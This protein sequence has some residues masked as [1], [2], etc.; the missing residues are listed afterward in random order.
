M[1][2]E[3]SELR[4]G[5]CFLI[6]L[7]VVLS[8][9]TIAEV[10][11]ADPIIVGKWERTDGADKYTIYANGVTETILPD[12]IHHGTW[13]YDG[14]SGY[15][16]IF[17][18]DF[19]PSGK[20]SFVDYVTVTSDGQKYSGI[21]NYGDDFHCV[22]VGDT[23]AAKSGGFPIVYVAVGGGIGAI[24]A[25]GVAVY[26]IFFAGGSA[27]SAG[28]SAGVS[29]GAGAASGGGSGSDG[30]GQNNSGNQLLLAQTDANNSAQAINELKSG[31]PSGITSE[32]GKPELIE[33]PVP[34]EEPPETAVA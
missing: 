9:I 27:A 28:A 5:L 1:K 23:T 2:I 4:I 34:E 10:N 32:F 7:F 22:R 6:A 17:R 19:G 15:I 20:A 24:A 12:G 31:K 3:G 26:F 30:G 16:F 25:V 8:L 33:E 13:E 29:G 14:S 18:W 21:N 11:A